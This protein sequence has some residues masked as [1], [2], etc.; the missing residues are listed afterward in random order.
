[1]F[2]SMSDWRYICV[3]PPDLETVQEGA[4]TKLNSFVFNVKQRLWV[5]ARNLAGNCG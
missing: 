1:M 2:S 4:V 3:C 5:T